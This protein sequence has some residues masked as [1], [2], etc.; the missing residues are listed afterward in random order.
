ML[1]INLQGTATVEYELP[2]AATC[3]WGPSND[4]SVQYIELGQAEQLAKTKNITVY[5]KGE[6]IWGN[7][8]PCKPGLTR[9]PHPLV[10]RGRIPSNFERKY[11]THELSGVSPPMA[12]P[13]VITFAASHPRILAGI[14]SG[15]PENI[16]V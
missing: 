7:E 9:N 6:L 11:G 1:L 12:R 5:G 4:W 2:W 3:L 8:P 10:H 13:Y 15:S 16:L 14:A